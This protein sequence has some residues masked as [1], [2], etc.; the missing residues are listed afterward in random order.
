M[1]LIPIVLALLL[2]LAAQASP[3]LPEPLI[4]AIKAD[5]VQY[6]DHTA[7]LIAAFGSGDGITGEQVDMSLALLRAKARA[8]AILPLLMADLDG[9]G[10]IGRGEV[11]VAEAALASAARGRLEAVFQ[12]ADAD[13]NA[14]VSGAELADL[15]E[16][17]ALAAISP[18]QL[19]QAKILMG[20]DADGDGRVTLA[21]V[22]QGLAGLGLMS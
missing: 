13:G 7:G 22:R 5:P 16:A 17:A 19:A 9:D 20:F 14:E 1:R 11:T 10:V 4:K 8:A 15:G 21:E 2:P 6:L 18:S 12:K 3:L